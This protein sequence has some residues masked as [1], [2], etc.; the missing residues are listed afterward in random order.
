MT[1]QPAHHALP[2]IN[3]HDFILTKCTDSDAS[4][5]Q[6]DCVFCEV[7]IIMHDELSRPIWQ[8]LFVRRSKPICYIHKTYIHCVSK[9]Q[10]I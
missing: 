10:Y 8:L 4:M 6:Y 3:K 5:F 9:K 1:I 7:H 2:M